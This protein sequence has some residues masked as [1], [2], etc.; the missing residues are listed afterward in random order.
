LLDC[1]GEDGALL[2]EAHVAHVA[3]EVVGQ[4][5]EHSRSE[6]WA[7]KTSF[8][9]E[10]IFERDESERGMLILIRGEEGC[11]VGLGC[12]AAGDCLGVAEGKQASANGG[13]G[14]GERMR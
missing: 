10:W 2:E 11:A 12:E 5:G 1:A 9:G 8:F 6:R 13:F 4:H 14:S 7:Q 3:V